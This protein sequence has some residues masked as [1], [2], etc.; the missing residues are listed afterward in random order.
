MQ[1]INKIAN[2]HKCPLKEP[3]GVVGR[4]D[5]CEAMK[6]MQALEPGFCL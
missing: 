6:R 3:T 1:K 2:V 5:I 4:E